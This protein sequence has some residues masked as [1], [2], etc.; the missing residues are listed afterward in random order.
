MSWPE[1]FTLDME[2]AYNETS[3]FPRTDG[4]SMHQRIYSDTPRQDLC[5]R[6]GASESRG[7]PME[8]SEGIY[9]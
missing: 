7:I 6:N 5:H 2:G 4:R 8:M 1:D 3:K 9:E